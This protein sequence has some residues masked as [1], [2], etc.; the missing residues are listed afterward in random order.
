MCK[1]EEWPRVFQPAYLLSLMLAIWACLKN[2][3]CDGG[4][5]AFVADYLN[6]SVIHTFNN[7]ILAAYEADERP[8]IIVRI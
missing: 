8:M 2:L 5:H 1:E 3:A 4:T 6:V 7:T